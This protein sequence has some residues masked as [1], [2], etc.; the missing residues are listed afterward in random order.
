MGRIVLALVAVFVVL[1]LIRIALFQRP[2][3]H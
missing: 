2:G 1:L 3:R